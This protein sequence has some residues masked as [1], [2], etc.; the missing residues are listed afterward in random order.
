MGTSAALF[1]VV[2]AQAGTQRRTG[3][4]I[5]ATGFPLSRERRFSVAGSN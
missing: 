5:N 2:P 3:A 1:F 4:E